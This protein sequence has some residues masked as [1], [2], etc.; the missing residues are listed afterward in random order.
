MNKIYRVLRGEGR[1]ILNVPQKED[2]SCEDFFIMDLRG[3]LKSCSQE[4][5]AS[6]YGDDYKQRLK[7]VGFFVDEIKLEDICTKEQQKTMGLD[8]VVGKIYLCKK[9]N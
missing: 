1:T 8:E 5:Y 7:S 6:I 3:R 4:D 9:R 2:D